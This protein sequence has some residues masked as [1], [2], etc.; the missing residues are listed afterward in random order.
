MKPFPMMLSMLAVG[1][2]SSTAMAEGT[3]LNQISLSA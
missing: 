1:I 2:L 3:G